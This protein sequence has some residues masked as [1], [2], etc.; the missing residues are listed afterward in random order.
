ML[1][2]SSTPNVGLKDVVD[3]QYID[4]YSKIQYIW[5][6][7]MLDLSLGFL[8]VAQTRSHLS[9]DPWQNCKTSLRHNLC[10]VEPGARK[11]V[12]QFVS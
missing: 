12:F 4:I 10:L 5:D 1:D 8:G 9:N 2:P 3:I 6:F 11:L 7:D